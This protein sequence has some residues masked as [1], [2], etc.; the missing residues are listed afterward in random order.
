MRRPLVIYDFAPATFWISLNMMKLLFTFLSLHGPS[1]LMVNEN[2]FKLQIRKIVSNR[3]KVLKVDR[4]LVSNE[5]RD[6]E[7]SVTLTPACLYP[8]A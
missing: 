5:G 1:H 3:C 4:L 7:K 2:L 6:S 8:W